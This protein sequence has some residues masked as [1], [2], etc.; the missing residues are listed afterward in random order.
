M[1]RIGSG[2]VIVAVTVLLTSLVA[3][4]AVGRYDSGSQGLEMPTN[5][6]TSEQT[7][8]PA[9]PQN[10]PTL[11]PPQD[12]PVLAAEPSGERRPRSQV[13]YVPVEAEEA[14]EPDAGNLGHVD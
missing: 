1:N 9:A 11:A 4:C 12:T 5:Q 14:R 6:A 2:M 10:E 8:P 7:P 3:A 13:I